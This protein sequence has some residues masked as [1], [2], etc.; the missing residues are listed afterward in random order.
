MAHD[1][2]IHA[3]E[4][5]VAICRDLARSASLWWGDRK[6]TERDEEG[7]CKLVDWSSD[8]R[9]SSEFEA[10]EEEEE[11]EEFLL[12]LCLF[13]LFFSF[14]SFLLLSLSALSLLCLFCGGGSSGRSASVVSGF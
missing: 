13:F 10:E 9:S 8:S 2:L 3:V 12:C 14:F 1:G 7:S 11:E 4:E 6:A 5:F